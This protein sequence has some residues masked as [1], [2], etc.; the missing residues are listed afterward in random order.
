MKGNGKMLF[1]VQNLLQA[2][3]LEQKSI[4]NALSLTADSFP[5]SKKVGILV[6]AC[7]KVSN[8]KGWFPKLMKSTVLISLL[9]DMHL[10]VF[11]CVCVYLPMFM[12][13]HMY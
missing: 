13:I 9:A 1:R 8:F 4:V 3:S 11:V 7:Q 10:F 2:I 6:R 5:D 12:H